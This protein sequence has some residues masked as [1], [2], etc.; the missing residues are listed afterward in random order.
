MVIKTKLNIKDK[1]YFLMDNKVNE[2]EIEKVETRNMFGVSSV[3]YIINENPAGSQY[4]TRFSE[5]ELFAT[6]QDLLDTL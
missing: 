5:S 4:T 2:A 3:F 6:K 1:C